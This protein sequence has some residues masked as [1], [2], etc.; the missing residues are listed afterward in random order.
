MQTMVGRFLKQKINQ[1][2]LVDAF[3]TVMSFVQVFRFKK[4]AREMEIVQ[5]MIKSIHVI[6][7]VCFFAYIFFII[8]LRC[9]LSFIYV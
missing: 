7:N 5:K 3:S 8:A 1:I 4:W 9:I 6:I 2:V